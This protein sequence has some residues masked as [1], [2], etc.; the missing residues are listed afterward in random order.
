MNAIYHH[1][2]H[3]SDLSDDFMNIRLNLCI[4][5]GVCASN[6]QSNAITLEKVRNVIPF[7]NQVELTAKLR[8]GR[9]H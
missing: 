5:C 7:K 4:G 9:A 3:K 1:W 2:P 6:C 8:E